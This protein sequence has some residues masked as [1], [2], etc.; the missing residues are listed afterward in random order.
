MRS[1]EIL[2]PFTR[3][4]RLIHERELFD[5]KDPLFFIMLHIF[6]GDG[7][8]QT[9]V[10]FFHRSSLTEVPKLA[11]RAMFVQDKRCGLGSGRCGPCLQ[12]AEHWE[13]DVRALAYLYRG[14][15]A[16]YG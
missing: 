1:V 5:C 13:R 11:G 14:A 15:A 7:S 2:C 9:Q 6:R 8:E 16:L 4:S 3:P 10:V 12:R